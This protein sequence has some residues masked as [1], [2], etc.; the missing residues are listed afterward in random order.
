MTDRIR[1]NDFRAQWNEVRD[2]ALEAM[3]RVGESGWLILGQEVKLFEEKLAETCGFPYSV[4]CGNGLDAIEIALRCLGIKTGDKVLTTPLSAFA[5]TLAILRAGGIPVFVDVD[6]T[7]LINLELTRQTLK[8]NPEIRFFVPVHLYG[9]ALSYDDLLEIK[10]E[11]DLNIIEDCAQAIGARSA[12]H[13]VGTAG[14]LA[15]TS[16]YPTKNLGALGDGGALLMHSKKFFEEAKCLRDYGQ[17]S[18]YVH[19]SMGMNSRLDELQAAI[20]RDAFLPRLIMNTLKRSTIADSY[21]NQIS[22]ALLKIPPKP[23]DS[24]S[25]WHLFPILVSGKRNAF[26][27]YLKQHGIESGVH[28]PILIPEQEALKNIKFEVKTGLELSTLFAQSEVSLPIHPF[29][30]SDQIAHVIR[31]CNAWQGE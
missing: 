28:Y 14:A 24:E 22:N 18:K 3:A 2:N 7:G 29:L 31:T 13:H 5:T 15:T 17:S 1:M 23:P 21:L 12:G 16:F 20:L 26:Q 11:F 9:H 19:T 30:G 25:V 4:G 6:E 10:K 27:T 8:Q